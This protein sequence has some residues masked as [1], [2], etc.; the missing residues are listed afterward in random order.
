MVRL[1]I[2]YHIEKINFYTGHTI[3]GFKNGPGPSHILDAIK[4]IMDSTN[5]K[6]NNTYIH[7]IDMPVKSHA[8]QLRLTHLHF[9]LFV[10]SLIFYFSSLIF[11]FF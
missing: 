4:D 11:K 7:D 10:N 3:N 8:T 2:G 1:F 9:N 5:I 6:I